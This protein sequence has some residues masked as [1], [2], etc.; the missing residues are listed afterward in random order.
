MFKFLNKKLNGYS[1]LNSA[2]EMWLFKWN[3]ILSVQHILK[4][5]T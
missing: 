2:C 3:W 5:E 1:Y 4:E